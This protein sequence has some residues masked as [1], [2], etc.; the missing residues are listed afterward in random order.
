MT[1]RD[2]P[3]AGPSDPYLS[4]LA[5]PESDFPELDELAKPESANPNHA[6]RNLT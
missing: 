6:E 1:E 3:T 5:G 2:D 4:S